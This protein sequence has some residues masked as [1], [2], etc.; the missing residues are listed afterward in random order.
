MAFSLVENVPQLAKIATAGA[1]CL[2]PDAASTNT[3][4]M[5]T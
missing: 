4:I 2:S 1:P 3:T 5:A